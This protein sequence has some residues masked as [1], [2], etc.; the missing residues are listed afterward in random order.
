MVVLGIRMIQQ[1][2]RQ[3]GAGSSLKGRLG[4]DQTVDVE[5]YALNDID[6]RR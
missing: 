5:G 1:A 2:I 4:R 3:Q 6:L